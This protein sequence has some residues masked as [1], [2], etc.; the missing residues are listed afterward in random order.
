MPSLPPL[1]P[2]EGMHPLVVH[3]PIALLM[4]VPLFVLVTAVTGSRAFMLSTL[5]LMVLGTA[6]AF[7][8]T[9]S[10]DEANA[11]MEV[12]SMTGYEVAEEHKAVAEWS[13]NVFLVL[14]IVYAVLTVLTLVRQ[15][16]RGIAPRLSLNLLFLLP[17]AYGLLELAEAAH[18]GGHLVHEFGAQAPLAELIEEPLED[19]D[20]TY[21]EG[22]DGEETADGETT[23]EETADEETTEEDATE[24]GD[25]DEASGE[26][27]ASEEA[28]D[29]DPGDQNTEPGDDP[30]ADDGQDEAAREATANESG[31]DSDGPADASEPSEPDEG[32]AS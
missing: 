5:L 11:Y 6:G 29:V 18:L 20:F 15:K 1:P 10:G 9:S 31:A 21:D 2:W 25:A 22:G 3:F 16:M 4:V 28:S 23:D 7:V 30:S 17:W 26:Q 14:T 27:D 12:D 19:D 24:E 13:R 32:D 8:A